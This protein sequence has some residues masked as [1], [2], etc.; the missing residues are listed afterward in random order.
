MHTL[1]DMNMH[2]N[3]NKILS[4]K[5]VYVLLFSLN[6]YLFSV[7][8]AEKSW[9]LSKQSTLVTPASH[10]NYLSNMLPKNNP[11]HVFLPHNAMLCISRLPSVHPSIR[12]PLGLYSHCMCGHRANA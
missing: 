8:T 9:N 6:E 2:D 5:L 10:T 3:S 1:I 4:V 12:L 11:K 7:K